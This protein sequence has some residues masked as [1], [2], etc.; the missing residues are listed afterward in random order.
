MFTL[1]ERRLELTY[2]TSDNAGKFVEIS[3]FEGELIQDFVGPIKVESSK[4][5]FKARW[6]VT[7]D[8]ND[9]RSGL[10]LTSI[11]DHF[12]AQNDGD[13]EYNTITN[14]LSLYIPLAKESTVVFHYFRFDALVLKGGILI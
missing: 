6:D 2:G 7:V 10:N 12:P 11:Q 9:P 14:A 4:T 8:Y 13:P 5:S 3:D 1:F